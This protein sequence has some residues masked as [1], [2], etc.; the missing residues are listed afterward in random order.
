MRARPRA[1]AK[2]R[3]L[4][5]FTMKQYVQADLEADREVANTLADLITSGLLMTEIDAQ[6]EE[7]GGRQ[8]D[9]R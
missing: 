3:G 8:R 2:T 4:R 6:G 1:T 5:V 9:P 7:H